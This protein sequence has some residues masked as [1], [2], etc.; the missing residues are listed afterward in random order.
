MRGQGSKSIIWKDKKTRFRRDVGVAS[1]DSACGRDNQMRVTWG[2]LT[3]GW[4]LACDR[5]VFP[6]QIILNRPMI[7]PSLHRLQVFYKQKVFLFTTSRT[8]VAINT[9]FAGMPSRD[10]QRYNTRRRLVGGRRKA[11]KLHF[12]D[13]TFHLPTLHFPTLVCTPPYHH[14]TSEMTL[15]ISL[16][17]PC[18]YPRSSSSHEDVHP[19]IAASSADSKNFTLHR[20]LY[21]CPRHLLSLTRKHTASRPNPFS[22]SS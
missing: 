6:Q 2:W 3:V 8:F 17:D 19:A 20:C 21:E 15:S 9:M 5:P 18:V 11:R 10:S 12:Q 7:S 14:H 4:L 1:E 13:N 22:R 16:R